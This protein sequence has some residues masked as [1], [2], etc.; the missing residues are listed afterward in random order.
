MQGN[1][2]PFPGP[3]EL[4]ETA[5]RV[6]DHLEAGEPTSSRGMADMFGCEVGEVRRAIA[7]IN[8]H[9][10]TTHALHLVT[11]QR[12][13]A[14]AAAWEGLGH[15]L[16]LNES[17]ELRVRHDFVA[18]SKDE[19]AFRENVVD[20][21]IAQIGQ[22]PDAAVVLASLRVR[23]DDMLKWDEAYKAAMKST[24]LAEQD[25]K[26]KFAKQMERPTKVSDTFDQEQKLMDC[27]YAWQEWKEIAAH[28]VELKKHAH[29]MRADAR[30]RFHEIMDNL[31]QLPLDF[32]D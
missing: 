11:Y 27:E 9:Y 22:S 16:A 13:V 8:Q 12:R 6:L 29:E 14:P 18:E 31:R 1:V 26:A 23:Y 10:P 20:E 7:E 4:S 19:R 5:V 2:V 28:G 25:A 32:G 24:R 3:S 21:V 30:A 17:G 15:H